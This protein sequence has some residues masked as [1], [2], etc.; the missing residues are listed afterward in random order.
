M[1]GSLFYHDR[2]AETMS[3]VKP[4]LLG[5]NV[6]SAGANAALFR[7]FFIAYLNL[8]FGLNLVSYPLERTSVSFVDC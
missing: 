6:Q 7:L 8:A 4:G 3:K 5:L 1:P 2:P